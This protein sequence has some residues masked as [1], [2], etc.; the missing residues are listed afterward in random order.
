MKPAYILASYRTPGCR[1]NKGKFRNTRPDE[2]AALAIRGLL[3]RTEI[4]PDNVDD[5]Y[6]GC[7]FP[8]AETR[9]SLMKNNRSH[10]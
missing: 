9:P 6:L 2:L 3:E 5:V 1:A 10:F 8:E 7:A 4:D